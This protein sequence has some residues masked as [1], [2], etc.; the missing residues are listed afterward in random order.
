MAQNK[1]E[2]KWIGKEPTQLADGCEEIPHRDFQEK[3]LPSM[4]P[5]YN[6]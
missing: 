3:A 1:T 5:V 6:S 2:Q 4:L